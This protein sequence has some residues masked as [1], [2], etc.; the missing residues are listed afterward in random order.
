[1]KKVNQRSLF[2]ACSQAHTPEKLSSGLNP[3]MLPTQPVTIAHPYNSPPTLLLAGG[4]VVSHLL[5]HVEN[6][7]HKL[8]LDGLEG[9]VL[10]QKL[11]RDLQ[12][13]RVA[14]DNTAD[15][16]KVLGDQVGDVV[17]DEDTADVQPTVGKRLVD[18]MMMGRVCCLGLLQ[19]GHRSADHRISRV[20][21][22]SSSLHTAPPPDTCS[23]D[24]GLGG[25]VV[26]LIVE[27]MGGSGGDEQNGL[28]LNVSLSLEVAVG[29]GGVK[30][31]HG[32][33]SR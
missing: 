13:Q 3:S 12:R 14:V 4:L 29:Q 20:G 22:T 10:L 30:V 23:L 31:L 21:P 9:C 24:A 1:M 7:P 2:Q 16:A 15:E 26:V 28:E 17:A 19:D 32:E 33:R 8:L 11:T 25:L 5:D 18:G 6:L 27:I